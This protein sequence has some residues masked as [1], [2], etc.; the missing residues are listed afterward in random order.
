[1]RRRLYLASWLGMTALV[2]LIWR[3]A[4]QIAPDGEGPFQPPAARL[5]EG[6]GEGRARLKPSSMVAAEIGDYSLEFTVGPSGIAAGGGLMVAFP[7]AWFANPFPLIKFVQTEDP[8]LPHHVGVTTSRPGARLAVGIDSVGLTG[9]VER[10]NH[11]I[12]LHVGEPGLQ[13]GDTLTVTFGRTT[14][15]YLIGEDTV[16]VA[17]DAAGDGRFRRVAEGAH[18]EVLCGEAVELVLVGPSQ[19]VVGRPVDLTL[20]AFDPYS[21]RAEFLAGPVQIT[22]LG[23][24]I[25]TEFG[26]RDLG[27]LK[28]TWTPTEPGWHWPEATATIFIN[29]LGNFRPLPL[30]AAGNP[31]GVTAAEPPL[32]LYWGDLHS[33]SEISK[34]AIGRGDF[35]YARDAARLDFFAPT[36]HADDDGNPLGDGITPEEW[37]AIRRRAHEFDQPGR[38]VTLLA[39][40][41]SLSGGHH[42]VFFR[43]LEGVPWPAHRV[44]DVRT[45]WTKLAEG[46]AITIPHHLGI[47]W[48]GVRRLGPPAQ[49]G[50]QPVRPPDEMPT[51]GPHLDWT[52]PQDAARRPLLE[53]YSL[54]GSSEGF[55]PED[56]LAYENARFTSARSH[57]GPHYARDAWARGLALGVVAASDNHQAQPGQRHGGLTAVFAPTLTR[58]SVF[59][60]LAARRTYGTTGERY[61]MELT[62]AGGRMGEAVVAAPPWG[63][64][65]LVAAPGPMRF[66]EIVGCFDGA[67]EFSPVARWDAPGRLLESSYKAPAGVKQGVLYARAE[68]MEPV[69]GRPARA[70]SS[71]IWVTAAP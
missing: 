61:F 22:G 7:K 53:I 30:K 48:G 4:A 65:I 33:H 20:T 18:Y 25:R 34:D 39:Y 51:R 2:G 70:W 14:A 45:L 62:L 9:K 38:F 46:E 27:Q 16:D 31:I 12:T 19:A 57:P 69:R 67:P 13:A 50:L 29:Q 21:N 6:L 58:E 26:S 35:A 24:P 44:R 54:H 47:T 32:K 1:M 10:F 55:D 15:P 8:A 17:V 56:P 60:A 11:T 71:P 68:L 3:L 66:V 43:S 41:C 40:E 64:T 42:N 63:G 5:A 49:P 59:D 37:E 36:E 52:L 23:E 28:I